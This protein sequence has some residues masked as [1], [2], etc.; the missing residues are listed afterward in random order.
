MSDPAVLAV[1]LGASEADPSEAVVTVYV[2]KGHRHAPIPGQLDGV[3]TRVIE[4]DAFRAYG[5]N[6]PEPKACSAK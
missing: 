4:T 1:G 6:E 3:R 2:E 5:W